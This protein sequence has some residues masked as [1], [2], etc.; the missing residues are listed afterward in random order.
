[1]AIF[2][3]PA[4]VPFSA[5][6]RSTIGG[7]ARCAE[8]GLNAMEVEFV[9]GVKMG[10]SLAEEAGAA[11][12]EKGVRL[13]VH[14]PYYINLLSAKAVLVKKS[15]ERIVDSLDR[16]ERMGADAVAVHAAYLGEL[17]S[18]KATELMKERT[19]QILAVLDKKGISNVRLGYETMAKKGQWGSLEEIIEVH[20]EHRRR[21]APYLDW[22][23]LYA[24]GGGSIDYEALLKTM[25]ELKL[26][27]INSHFTCVKA[28]KAGGYVDIHTPIGDKHPDFAPLAKLL[29]R[30]SVDITLI[31]ESPLLEQD[32]LKMKEQLEKAGYNW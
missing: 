6:E 7:I 16:G 31:C 2:L 9:R 18:E 29:A 28:S 27:H 10:A 12:K 3:G 1:M 26:D 17:T 22:G 20:R 11:A 23:H 24:R 25:K 19:G 30:S 8:L 5:K 21:V 14:A 13:S 15:I 32:A 4:G